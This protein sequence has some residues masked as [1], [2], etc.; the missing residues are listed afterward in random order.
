MYA[1]GLKGGMGATRARSR[2]RRWTNGEHDDDKVLL[3]DIDLGNSLGI[4]KHLT[5]QIRSVVEVSVGSQDDEREGCDEEW[6]A[7]RSELICSSHRHPREAR[8]LERAGNGSIAA[9]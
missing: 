1:R 4:I 9:T 3:L 2:E 7:I 6:R 5:C 8:Q